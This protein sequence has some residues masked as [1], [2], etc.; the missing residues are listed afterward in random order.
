MSDEWETPWDVFNPLND[1]FN[2]T[3]DAAATSANR[4]VVQ[5]WSAKDDGLQQSWANEVVWC[6]PPYLKQAHYKW[7]GKAVESESL[8][9]I[10][11]C[12]LVP[13]AT[14]TKL[15]H[16]FIFPTA[17]HILFFRG[18]IRF[19][20]KGKP[21]CTPR[22]DSALAVWNNG[23]HSFWELLDLLNGTNLGHVMV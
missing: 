3:I 5:F 9:G 17:S 23:P 7:V 1:I 12:L 15:W 20:M 8:Y 21:H 19:L 13:A 14:G 10:T 16:E 22:F 4:K 11:S 18:R 2:F 6:N